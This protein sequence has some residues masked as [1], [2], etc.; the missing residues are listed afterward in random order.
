M[1]RVL[2]GDR[3]PQIEH[4]CG[5]D[6]ASCV[7]DTLH[8]SV[9]TQ[10]QLNGIRKASHS[11]ARLFAFSRR[12]GLNALFLK[13]HV[14]PCRVHTRPLMNSDTSL[15]SSPGPA[16]GR[17]GLAARAPPPQGNG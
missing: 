6:I 12:Q 13:R 5:A 1:I 15:Y 14:M 17:V 10:V 16:V 4:T 2:F 8:Q 9:K 7:R 3:L 11:F